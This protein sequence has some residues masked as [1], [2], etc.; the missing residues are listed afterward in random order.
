[1]DMGIFA[2]FTAAFCCNSENVTD[3]VTRSAFCG[4]LFSTLYNGGLLL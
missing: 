4:V 1:M 3:M 2:F